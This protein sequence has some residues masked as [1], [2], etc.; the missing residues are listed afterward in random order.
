MKNGKVPAAEP[1]EVDLLSMQSRLV[2]STAEDRNLDRAIRSAHP[3]SIAALRS[4]ACGDTIDVLVGYTAGAL[5]QNGGD[6]LSMVADISSAVCQA[7]QYMRNSGIEP[8]FRLA[9]T[10]KVPDNSS[11]SAVADL[12]ALSNF[13]DGWNDSLLDAMLSAEADMLALI[14]E[15][16]R[17]WGKQ[18]CGNAWIMQEASLG[19]ATTKNFGTYSVSSLW[20]IKNT[21][22]LT[23]ELGHNL[24]MHHYSEIVNE[25]SGGLFDDSCGWKWNGHRS[26]MAHPPGN[27]VN[28]FSNPSLGAGA[29]GV[30]DNART[31]NI[32]API[33]SCFSD[34]R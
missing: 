7:G 20:C 19:F 32:S 16:G 22:T 15:D 3:S 29:P 17:E 21:E 12:Q 24:G 4:N 23:H 10:A 9:G 13:Q 8:V 30:A 26:I 18:W 14:V 34:A 11:G 27:R 28:L 6:T 1:K 25:G 2:Q 5:A 33:A 31:G